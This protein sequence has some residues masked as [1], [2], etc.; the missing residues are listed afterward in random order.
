MS[1]DLFSMF[2]I[3][4][5][6]LFW[7]HESVPFPPQN[8]IVF[9]AVHG[10]VGIMHEGMWWPWLQCFLYRTQMGNGTGWPCGCHPLTSTPF[11]R[12]G[13]LF[14]W[15]SGRRADFRQQFQS[16]HLRSIS[17]VPFRFSLYTCAHQRS[18]WI[19]FV[20]C[21]RNLASKLDQWASVKCLRNA[22]DW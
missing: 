2:H 11:H 18:F 12:I 21:E 1:V 5:C 15:L 17:G 10:W 14:L 22:H 7:S 19:K 4:R 20:Q 8:K 6:F 9:I 3:E 16:G 13:L